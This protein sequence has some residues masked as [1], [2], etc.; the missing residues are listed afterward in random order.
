MSDLREQW[1]E[2]VSSREE[3]QEDEYEDKDLALAFELARLF[4]ADPPSIEQVSYFVEEAGTLAPDVPDAPWTIKKSFMPGRRFDWL[5]LIN[6]V[7]C[8]IESG[9][10]SEMVPLGRL[11]LEWESNDSGSAS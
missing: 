7:L 9:E 10:G 6:D 8:G 3:W 4:Q 2:F 1:N 11:P 5:V